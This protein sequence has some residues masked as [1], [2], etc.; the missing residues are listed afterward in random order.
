MSV[1]LAPVPDVTIE[2]GRLP[3]RRG[4][5]TLFNEEDAVDAGATIVTRAIVFQNCYS[6]FRCVRRNEMPVVIG[7]PCL[8]QL[9]RSGDYC[10]HFLRTLTIIAQSR[11]VSERGARQKGV[12]VQVLA[13]GL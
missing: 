11:R 4:I 13:R 8:L 1:V 5:A 3:A 9:H 7:A 6:H 12:R 10:R 2:V